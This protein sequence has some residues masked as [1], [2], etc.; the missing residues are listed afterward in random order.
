M[1]NRR[2]DQ[3]TDIEDFFEISNKINMIT[4]KIEN[5]LFGAYIDRN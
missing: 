5:L 3:Q 2:A 4:T 1:M